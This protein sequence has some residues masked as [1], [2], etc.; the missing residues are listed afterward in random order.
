MD[1]LEVKEM[2]KLIKSKHTNYGK[3]SDHYKLSEIVSKRNPE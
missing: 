2:E 3:I 1:E